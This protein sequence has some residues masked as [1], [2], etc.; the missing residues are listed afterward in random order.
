MAYYPKAVEIGA[1][2]RLVAPSG[3]EAV[4]NDPLDPNYVGMLTEVTGLDSAEVRESADDLVEA[5]G[6]QHG[7]FYFG[8]RP[9]T[10]TARVYGHATVAERTRRIDLAERASIALRGDAFM[11]WKPS[12]RRDNLVTNPRAANDT[13]DWLN[14]GSGLGAGGTLTRVTGQTPPV[15]TTAFQ[16][17]T[18]G[19]GAA[20]QGAIIAIPTTP[21]KTYAVTIAAKRSAGTGTASAFVGGA[22]FGAA[23]NSNVWGTRTATFV[24]GATT[25][26]VGVRQAD[27]NTAAS[28]FQFSD[29]MVREGTDT[30]YGDGDTA[31]WYWSGS[32]HRSAS[33]D[34][35]EMA[36]WVRRQQ[37][38]RESGQWIK[39]IQLALVSQFAPVFSANAYSTSFNGSSQS[40]ENHGSYPSYPIVRIAGASTNPTFDIEGRTFHT[41]GLTLAGG[42]TVEYDMLNHTGLFTAGGRAGQSANRYIDFANTVTWPY[43]DAASSDDASISGGGTFQVVWRD[44]WA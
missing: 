24:A 10:M 43:I 31:G 22:N 8:R 5:D 9:I 7:D 13:Q 15:G 36:T 34:Y 42:E 19:T 30:S 29:V 1:R 14:A 2:Y 25:T 37:P 3:V 6:G 41:S 20:N 21:G 18:T 16:V 33:G 32:P 4:F 23:I 26:Y 17:A 39:E 27:S 38:V 28:T 11:S 35:I 40:V 12:S 44:T